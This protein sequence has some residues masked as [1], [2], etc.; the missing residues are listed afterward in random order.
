MLAPVRTI[1]SRVEDREACNQQKHPRPRNP[2][3]KREEP[4]TPV[5]EP[6]KDGEHI[7]ITA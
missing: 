7:D 4:A 1:Y 2:N 3:K 5:P 6:E